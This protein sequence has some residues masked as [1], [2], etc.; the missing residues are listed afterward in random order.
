MRVRSHLK[1]AADF[2]VGRR[3]VQ[4]ALEE[5][6]LKLRPANDPTVFGASR[7]DA[8]VH[9]V[10]TAA[11]VGLIKTVHDENDPRYNEYFEPG[12]ITKRL[13]RTFEESQLPILYVGVKAR[14]IK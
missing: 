2:W 4:G 1:S 5:A 7:T 9:A 14:R 13:N 3:T 6:I 8:G 11:T 12:E 10:Q